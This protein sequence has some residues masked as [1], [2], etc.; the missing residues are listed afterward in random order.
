MF[1]PNHMQQNLESGFYFF[2]FL[3][4]FD[5]GYI[6]LFNRCYN[7][8]DDTRFP[9]IVQTCIDLFKS[10]AMF[11]LLSNMSG[12]KLHELAGGS[13]ESESEVENEESNPES[14]GSSSAKS[15]TKTTETEEDNGDTSTSNSA[16]NTKDKGAL[17]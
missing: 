9:D 17:I 7:Q 5:L 3:Y 10:D 16:S 12:L 11:L 13:S 6:F 14:Q 2:I 4:W 15:R 8:A 1:K